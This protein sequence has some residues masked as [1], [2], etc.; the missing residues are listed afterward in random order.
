ML[1]TAK[2]HLL[3][4]V[5]LS[6]RASVECY[7][8]L[9][10]TG[11]CTLLRHTLDLTLRD[12]SFS[13]FLSPANLEEA[14]RVLTDLQCR[15]VASDTKIAADSRVPCDVYTRCDFHDDN[16]GVSY[17]YAWHPESAGNLESLNALLS[18]SAKPHYYVCFKE[19]REGEPVYHF[20]MVRPEKLRDLQA[21][22]E[23]ARINLPPLK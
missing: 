19:N 2:R 8:E 13:Y 5:E 20:S 14:I 12:I 6:P 1:V 18:N 23:N 21:L 7:L 16:G 3:G 11:A 10:G 9:N 17:I 15:Q 4:C 22:L